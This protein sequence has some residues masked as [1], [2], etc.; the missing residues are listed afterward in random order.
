MGKK[1]K[2]TGEGKVKRKGNSD[3]WT[4]GHDSK[5]TIRARRLRHGRKDRDCSASRIQCARLDRRMLPLMHCIRRNLRYPL[6]WHSLASARARMR[7]RPG[8]I[9]KAVVTVCC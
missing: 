8:S 1:Q 4:L 2:A 6:L 3:G 7:R 5:D 9:S